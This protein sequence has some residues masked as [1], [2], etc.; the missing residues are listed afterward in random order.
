MN[1]CMYCGTVNEPNS[2][3]C[4]K[5]GKPM[6]A[7]APVFQ[8]TAPVSPASGAAASTAKKL[9]I[10]ALV[11]VACA[12][13]LQIGS[14]VVVNRS[15]D[16]ILPI[17]AGRLM[18]WTLA[19]VLPLF[20]V[21]CAYNK[22]SKGAM[23]VLICAVFSLVIW[24]L[25]S[26][27]ILLDIDTSTGALLALRNFCSA[28]HGSYLLMYFRSIIHL[29]SFSTILNAL[30]GVVFSLLFV[31]SNVLSLLAGIKLRKA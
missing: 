6:A 1:F 22:V 9:S 3:F 17:L 27:V 29:R 21:F 26:V 14:L 4:A 16:N 2:R 7:S 31:G 13:L 12:I 5:C 15:S 24:L 8:N 18:S 20:C 11:S 25:S 19:A 23:P 10:A 30:L 28:V